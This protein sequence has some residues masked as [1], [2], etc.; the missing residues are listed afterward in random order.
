MSIVL[1]GQ[2]V[3]TVGNFPDAFLLIFGLMYALH[4]SYPKPM[5]HTFEFVQKVILGLENGKLAPRLLS[6]KNDLAM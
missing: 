1:E 4:L 6:L 2:E 3:L 5:D